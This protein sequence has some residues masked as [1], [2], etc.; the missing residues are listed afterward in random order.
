MDIFL[1]NGSDLTIFIN[2]FGL[3]ELPAKYADIGGIWGDLYN[4]DLLWWLAAL[5]PTHYTL[6]LL[7]T[8]PGVA[9][10]ALTWLTSLN[11]KI[12]ILF[13]L[14][15]F[16]LQ[17]WLLSNIRSCSQPPAPA[18]DIGISI[19]SSLAFVSLF[20][21]KIIRSQAW[22]AKVLSYNLKYTS[23]KMSSHHLSPDICGAQEILPSGSMLAG[24]QWWLHSGLRLLSDTS[25]LPRLF[26]VSAGANWWAAYC[27]LSVVSV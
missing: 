5:S 24:S 4:N 20:N 11:K 2:M 18:R 26:L 19:S 25:L 10:M 27:I 13:I 6:I 8:C 7:W 23:F 1:E 21:T 14:W 12:S 15:I 9:H 16:M 3:L 22:N 17:P